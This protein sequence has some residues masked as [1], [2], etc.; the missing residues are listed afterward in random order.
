MNIEL[1]YCSIGII[2]NST[3]TLSYTAMQND[4]LKN[5]EIGSK[6]KDINVLLAGRDRE[7]ERITMWERCSKILFMVTND[8]SRCK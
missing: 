7:E 3:H 2:L 5:I 4:A 8:E 1:R 6:C